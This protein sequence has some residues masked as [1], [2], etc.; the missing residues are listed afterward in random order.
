[1]SKYLKIILFIIFLWFIIVF[2]YA[3]LIN[4]NFDLFALLIS[5]IAA[6]L[7]IYDYIISKK[8]SKAEENEKGS[9]DNE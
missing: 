4:N 6:G 9:I 8:G 2:L 1:L 7:N 5:L 3:L